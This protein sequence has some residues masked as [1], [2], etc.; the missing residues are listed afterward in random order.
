M[1]CQVKITFI[2]FVFSE[3]KE[4]N[5]KTLIKYLEYKETFGNLGTHEVL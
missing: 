4:K 1:P 5:W 2:V 3:G